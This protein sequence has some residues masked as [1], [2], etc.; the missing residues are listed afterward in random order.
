MKQFM[1]SLVLAVSLVG[2]SERSISIVDYNDQHANDLYRISF[3]HPEQF[4]AGYD[5]VQ[6]QIWTIDQFTE[7]NQKVLNG[8]LTNPSY[9]KRVL[10]EDGTPAGYIAFNKDKE[11]TI[12]QFS[13]KS[14]QTF[15]SE[16]EKLLLEHNKHFK[17]TPEECIAYA[18]IVAIAVSDAYQR[19][20]YAKA[21]IKNALEHIKNER[22]DIR[23]VELDVNESNTKARALY[24]SVGFVSSNQCSTFYKNMGMILYTK[25]L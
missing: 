20:G 24:E 9:I 16:M 23:L 8:I 7:E 5:L 4:F 17:R 19:R 2:A 14:G 12:E 13:E 21:L 22:P 15:T 3:E 10:I 1:Y 18:K 25:H 11:L 6:K